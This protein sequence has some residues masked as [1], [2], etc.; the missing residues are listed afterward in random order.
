M[1]ARDQVRRPPEPHLRHH[2]RD[3]AG[4]GA[5][6]DGFDFGEVG[7]GDGVA[8][9]EGGGDAGAGGGLRGGRGR[10]WGGGCGR[11][12]GFGRRV[13]IVPGV[14]FAL[15]DAV[16]V[17]EVV[18]DGA[19]VAVGVFEAGGGGREGGFEVVAPASVGVGE[20]DPLLLD[21]FAASHDEG[22]ADEGEVDAEG[23]A[24]AVAGE[25]EEVAEA[26]AVDEEVDGVEAEGGAR[27]AECAEEGGEG[28]FWTFGRVLV[29][30]ICA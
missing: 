16:Q 12:F 20:F 19:V 14:D 26:G 7:G 4:L 23:A 22:V 24:R 29:N 13:G 10:C 21:A 8:G 30:V 11:G 9:G 17:A 6:A 1:P 18:L 28:A 5:A 2:A 27:D 15:D 3:L 25:A